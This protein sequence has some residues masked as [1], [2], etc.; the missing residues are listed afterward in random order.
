MIKRIIDNSDRAYMHLKNQ[1]LV[2]EKQSGIAGQVLLG[3]MSESVL[4]K[5]RPC[6]FWLR[7]ITLWQAM[8]AEVVEM[9][10]IACPS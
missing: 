7:Y 8:F 6:L 3:L 1:H 10:C 9:Q 5:K 4:Y 2:I